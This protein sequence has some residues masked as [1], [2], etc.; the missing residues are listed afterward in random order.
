MSEKSSYNALVGGR[1]QNVI[2][3][4]QLS[5]RQVLNK[6]EEKG[7]NISQS[8]MSKLLSGSSVHPLQVA[9]LCDVLDLNVAEVMSLNQDEEIH[10]KADSGSASSQLITDARNPAFRPYLGDFHAYFYTTKNEEIIHHGNI[11][12]NEDPKTHQCLAD[13]KFKTGEKDIEGKDIQKHYTGTVTCS[14][15]MHTK[16]QTPP[17]K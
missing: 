17:K 14:I 5:Q 16:T 11:S 8:A 1:L 13:F 12:F 10:I 9:Q 15:S 4:M 2:S 7:Y 3:T 6:C